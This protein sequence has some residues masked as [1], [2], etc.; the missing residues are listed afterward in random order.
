MSAGRGEVCHTCE[1]ERN[2]RP[3]RTVYTTQIA[4]TSGADVSDID[5]RSH[6]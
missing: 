1:G 6:V 5:S 2:A 3:D 4:G